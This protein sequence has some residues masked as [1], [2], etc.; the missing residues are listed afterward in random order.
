MWLL[1]NLNIKKKDFVLNVPHLELSGKGLMLL[2][3]PSGAGKSTFLRVLLG[4][5]PCSSFVWKVQDHKGEMDFSKKSFREKRLGVVLQPPQLFPHMTARKNILYAAKVR[6]VPISEA[7]AFLKEGVQYLSLESCLNNK[8]F[9]LSGGEL[10]RVAL[11]RALV[12]RPRFLILD[13]PFSA[14]DKEMQKKAASFLKEFIQKRNVPALIVAHKVED[15]RH[16]V[17]ESIVLEKGQ[18]KNQI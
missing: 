16:L 17:D 8:P 1:E 9:A 10:Q 4:M 6:N 3:G 11:L 18:L 14:L 7:Q 2:E 15:W 12:G 5:E 13:E